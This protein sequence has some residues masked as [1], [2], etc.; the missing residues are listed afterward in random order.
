MVRRRIELLRLVAF[1][2]WKGRLCESMVCDCV[3]IGRLEV[4]GGLD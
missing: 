4:L 3:G 2:S 1:R